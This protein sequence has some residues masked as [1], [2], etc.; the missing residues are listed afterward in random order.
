MPNPPPPPDKGQ[1]S[2]QPLWPRILGFG[3]LTVSA[4]FILIFILFIFALSG[5]NNFYLF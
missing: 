2:P 3:C 1:R 4:I 5:D